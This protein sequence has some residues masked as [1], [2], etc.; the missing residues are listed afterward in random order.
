LL[1]CQ[2]CVRNNSFSG[3]NRHAV[4]T[5]DALIR[6]DHQKVGPFIK[7]IDRAHRYAV[8]IFAFDAVLGDDIGHLG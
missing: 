7:A 8:G 3:T 2:L 5:I 4:T 6:M 1:L